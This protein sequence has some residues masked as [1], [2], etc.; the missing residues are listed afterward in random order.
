MSES[1]DDYDYLESTEESSTDSDKS[2]SDLES[3]DYEYSSDEETGLT[4]IERVLTGTIEQQPDHPVTSDIPETE[5]ELLMQMLQEEIEEDELMAQTLEEEEVMRLPAPVTVYETEIVFDKPKEQYGEF[6]NL[7]D[8]ND[9][10]S[11]Y[12]TDLKLQLD[13]KKWS[14]VEEYVQSQK[15]VTQG[16]SGNQYI[17]FIRAAN[18]QNKKIALGNQNPGRIGS[19]KLDPKIPEW[20][21]FTINVVIDSFVN[22]GLRPRSDWETVRI[23][24][25][26]NAVTAKFT[27]NDNLRS[28]LLS[29][30]DKPI[31]QKSSKDG[32][33]L[34]IILMNLRSSFRTTSVPSVPTV[35]TE[36]KATIV[37]S[38]DN[39]ES[40]QDFG[41]RKAFSER[42]YFLLNA[43]G[44]DQPGAILVGRC[45]L[46]IAKTP[47]VSYD[48]Q[49]TDIIDYV[50]ANI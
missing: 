47:G 26:T 44:L 14:S 30:G 33:Q 41:I 25:L 6:S 12:A 38:R 50:K 42:A 36:V 5:D 3:S 23:S 45:Y 18:T 39:N 32:N 49:I 43:E 15:Y 9:Q 1:D 37:V 48:K 27:Q 20:E 7:W 10:K 28:I 13:G 46:N 40:E 4:G 35:S 21:S 31:K 19:S 2:Y 8:N 22:H 11:K 16:S 34:G 17:D 29:T 24:V